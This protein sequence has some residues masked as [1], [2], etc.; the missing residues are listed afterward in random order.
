MRKHFALAVAI[1]VLAL[2]TNAQQPPADPPQHLA[3]DAAN[4]IQAARDR[5]GNLLNQPHPSQAA[6]DSGIRIL[7]SSLRYLESTPARELAYGNRYL[8]FRRHDVS[9]DLAEAYAIDHKPD[10]AF[11]YL[12]RM[13]ASGSFSSM[14]NVLSTDSFLTPLKTDPRWTSILG[15]LQRQG[16]QWKDSAFLM[17]YKPEL[18][19]DE[20]V[21]GLSLLWSKAKYN[22]AN[23]DGVDIDWDRIYLDYLPQ[24]RNTTSTKDY[25]KVLM[26]FYAQLKDGHTNVYPPNAISKEFYSRPPMRTAL[27]EGRVF[28]TEVWSDSLRRLGFTPG[29]EILAIDGQPVVP[30]AEKNIAP[31][32]SS[33]TPQDLRVRAFNYALLA[34]ADTPVTLHCREAGGRSWTKTIGRTGYPDIKR[35]PAVEF[36]RIGNIAYLALNAFEDRNMVKQV[37]S[38]FPEI[39]KCS[40]MVIDVR[41][42]GGGSGDLGFDILGMLTD[43]PF[44]ISEARLRKHRSAYQ[45]EIE[46][47]PFLPETW[48]ANG[49]HYF[50]KPVAL[51]IGPQTFSAAEDFTVAF[52]ALHRGPLIGRATGGSTGAPLGF[53]LPGG[54]TARVCA[55]H[56]TYP[57]G[58]EFVGIGIL[59]TIPVEPSIHD[60][61][62][63]RDAALEKAIAILAK[64][65]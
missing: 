28:V 5:A 56:D 37:D 14:V 20:K 26:R 51:L 40:A 61:Q 12:D 47:D 58:K 38:L 33:S 10:S 22:F 6:I 7:D 57:G 18:S 16:R 64:P 42:N 11:F 41:T 4:H 32:Q 13:V 27:V 9:A 1:G 43:K 25:Y 55:K 34:G 21:A 45:E 3:D 23:F 44:A 49:K 2:N 52:D 17:P 50:N 19:E 8:Y 24:V 31:Y 39:D 30:Y 54:G 29:L 65:M 60:L 53:P 35:H 36:R 15:K 46:W 62:T 63:G 48:R 59:P